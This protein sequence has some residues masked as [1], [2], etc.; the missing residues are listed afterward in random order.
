MSHCDSGREI[1]SR[2]SVQSDS[3]NTHGQTDNCCFCVGGCKYPCHGRSLQYSGNR[4]NSMYPTT[5][6][7]KPAVVIASL[8]LYKN[9]MLQSLLTSCINHINIVCN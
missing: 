3:V 4:L 8:K 5:P 2:S 6:V 1:M 9:G 7:L